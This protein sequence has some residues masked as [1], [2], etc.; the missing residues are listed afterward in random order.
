MGVFFNKNGIIHKKTVPY[1]EQQNG[2]VERKNRTLLN[3]A[4]SLLKMGQMKLQRLWE[5]AISTNCYL[6]NRT[7]TA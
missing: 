2:I 3:V 5:D 7:H 1:N 4:R 6:Q